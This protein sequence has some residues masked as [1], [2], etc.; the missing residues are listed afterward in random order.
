[1]ISGSRILVT[2]LPSPERG[3]KVATALLR[4]VVWVAGFRLFFRR[5][6]SD[7]LNKITLHQSWLSLSPARGH[8][9]FTLAT[10]RK[11][12]SKKGK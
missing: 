12:C 4:T 10:L 9:P 3:G 2:P 1:M 8:A 6:C 11:P 5:R 7:P